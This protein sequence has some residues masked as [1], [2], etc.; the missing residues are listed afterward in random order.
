MKKILFLIILFSVTLLG[1]S[2][3]PLG[4]IEDDYEFLKEID[5]IYEKI[6]YNTMINAL[7]VDQGSYIIIF[8]FKQCPF[9]VE[10]IPILNEV[11]IEEGFDKILYHDIYDMR[12]NNTA[13]YKLLVGY[14]D[15]KVGDLISRDDVKT[16]VVPDVYFV[17]NGVI[18]GHHI[19]TILNDEG[20]YIRNLTEEETNQVKEIYRDLIKSIK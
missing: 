15:N 3:D 8:A 5:H 2:K 10:V 4:K 13:E 6:D 19:A 12:Y 7:T 17:R 14:L 20:K 18:L 9:C 1:C 16:L 11:A